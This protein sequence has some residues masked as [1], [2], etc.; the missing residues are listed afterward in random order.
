MGRP[1]WTA[2]A[3]LLEEEEKRRV[4][5]KVNEESL[6]KRHENSLFVGGQCKRLFQH[7]TAGLE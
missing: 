2:A 5:R 4:D 1:F 7:W 3:I 6:S